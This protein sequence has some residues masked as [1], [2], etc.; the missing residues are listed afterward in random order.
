MDSLFRD[1][2]SRVVSR[3]IGD[4]MRFYLFR[5]NGLPDTSVFQSEN[6]GTR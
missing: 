1:C 5:T 3:K 4:Q 6:D 2:L